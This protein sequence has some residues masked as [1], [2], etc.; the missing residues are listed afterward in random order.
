MSKLSTKFHGGRQA[1]RAIIVF[2]GAF[3]SSFSAM[4]LVCSTDADMPIPLGTSTNVDSPGAPAITNIV[5]GPEFDGN[6]D[7]LDFQLAIDHTYTGDLFVTLTSPAGTTVTLLDRPGRPASFFGC[8][9]DDVSVTL[10]DAA[11]T[12]AEDQCSAAA[13]SIAGTRTPSEPLSAFNGEPFTGTWVLTAV[14]HFNADTGTIL[15]SSNCLD[16]NTTPVTISSFETRRRG[17]SLVAKWQTS[18]EAFNIGFHLW[19][20]VAGDWQQLNQ[21]LINS[22]SIDSV[23]PQNYRSR[24][25][26]LELDDEVTEVGI[27]SVSTSGEEEFYGPFAIGERYGEESV[28]QYIDWQQYRASHNQSMQDAGYVLRRG[29]WVKANQ[30]IIDRDNRQKARYQDAL[31]EIG[32][33]GIYRV[34]YETLLSQGID[35]LGMPNHKLALTLNN[36]AVPRIVTPATSTRNRFGPGAEIIFFARE[37]S[38]NE[39]RYIDTSFYRLS[40]DAELVLEA[41]NL[42]SQK[43][44]RKALRRSNDV[45]FSNALRATTHRQSIE[46]GENKQ[47]TFAL[48][49]DGWFDSSIRAI[50]QPGNKSITVSVP[51]SADLSQAAHLSLDFVGVVNRARI[52]ADGDGDLEPNHHYKVYLNRTEHADPVFEGFSNG[53]ELIELEIATLGQLRHGDN[54]LELELIPD[55][56][57]NVDIAYFIEGSV[58]YVTVNMIDGPAYSFSVLGSDPVIEVVA[59]QSALVAAYSSDDSGNFAETSIR[60]DGDKLLVLSPQNSSLRTPAKLWF[61]APDGYLEP[62][63]I[64]SASQADPADLDLIDIDYVVIADASLIGDDLRRFVDAQEELGRRTKVVATQNIYNRYS[65][66]AALPQSIASYL[67][68]QAASSNYQYVLLVGGHTYDYLSNTA[69]DNEPLINLLPSFYRSS[70]DLSGILQQI[71]TAVPFVDFDGDGRP[72][73][74]IG[75]WPV[76]DLTQ[77]KNVV[78]KTLVWHAQGSHKDQKTALFIAGAKESKSDFSSSSERLIPSLGLDYN[79]WPNPQRVFADDIAVD[80]SVAAD[81]K[82]AVTRD[83]IVDAINQ[84]PALTVFSGHA[85]PSVWGRQSYVNAEVAQRFTNSQAPSIVIPL[86]CYTTYYEGLVVKSLAESLLTDSASGAVALSGAALL[87]R[88]GDN[89]RFGR[90]LLEEL[91]VTGLDLGSAVLKVKQEIHQYSERHQGVVYNWTTLGDP[92]LSFG[93]P[94]VRPVIDD[95]DTSVRQ[96]K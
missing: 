85:S 65:N 66:G 34:S 91:T 19:G 18:S 54:T 70:A 15:S 22:H 35:Y 45:D 4:A 92:T 53:I 63:S 68:Q 74:A 36:Q 12:A 17:K 16:A 26:I 64:E 77:L 49:G 90:R 81:D 41:P 59:G 52:D 55:N 75:R 47:Y 46:F 7:D 39:I 96:S 24:I 72:D 10:D 11:A 94:N 40:L 21:R 33:S 80:D 37:L 2:I 31:L 8:A 14:D 95:A 87:S 71:P 69:T 43:F 67:A 76:R 6:V 27:S 48:Q 13:P 51:T 82:L 38:E 58:D 9:N 93:L 73:K 57:Y 83:R 5:V 32:E 88:S 61:I 44:N 29:R 86:A 60:Q 30:R 28:P 56:G 23:E 20:K 1:A 79:P 42:N 78:D 3:L 89:E 62:R 84:G 50:H 25:N